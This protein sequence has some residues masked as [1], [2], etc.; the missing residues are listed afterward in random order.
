MRANNAL[1]KKYKNSFLKQGL[2]KIKSYIK[3]D[4]DFLRK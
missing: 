4:F 2:S 1:I 3:D